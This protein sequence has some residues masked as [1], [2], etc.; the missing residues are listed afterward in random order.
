MYILKN[1]SSNQIIYLIFKIFIMLSQ[2]PFLNTSCMRFSD[3]GAIMI[4]IK[5]SLPG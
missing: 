2:I 3:G 1:V 4:T 5:A